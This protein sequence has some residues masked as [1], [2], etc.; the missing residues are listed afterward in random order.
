M[1][2]PAPSRGPDGRSFGPGRPVRPLAASG[3]ATAPMPQL[4]DQ[5]AAGPVGISV[6]GRVRSGFVLTVLLAVIGTLMAAAV[7]G[8]VVL[9]ALGLRSAV[10]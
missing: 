3:G 6:W 1:T 10:S 5:W 2:R 4:T 7:A 9:F 8:A